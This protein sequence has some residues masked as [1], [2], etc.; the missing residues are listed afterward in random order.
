MGGISRKLRIML[1]AA[2]ALAVSCGTALAVDY[3]ITDLAAAL[4]S[5]G[6]NI[7]SGLVYGNSINNNGDVVG[8]ASFANMGNY[9]AAL[10]QN[11][12]VTDLGV[13][14][15]P[16]L[17]SQSSEAHYITDSG[18]IV[19]EAYSATTAIDNTYRQ[20]AIFSPGSAPQNIHSPM[21][22]FANN[23]FAMA[24]GN[25]YIL[26]Q[27]YNDNVTTMHATLWGNGTGDYSSVTDMN[28]TSYTSNASGLRSINSSGQIVGFSAPIPDNLSFT[29]PTLW[30]TDG[31]VKYLDL[32]KDP[33]YSGLTWEAASGYATDIN[34]NGQVSVMFSGIGLSGIWENDGSFTEIK[35]IDLLQGH[36]GSELLSLRA[37]NN[38]G[39]VAGYITV[40]DQTSSTGF[41]HAVVYENGHLIDL[42]ALFEGSG[43]YLLNALDINDKGQILV[44]AN[45]TGFD[46]S[47]STTL[48]LTPDAAPVPIPTALP[49]F[50]SGLAALGIWRRRFFCA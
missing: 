27:S 47:W 35:P 37:I 29:R 32:S 2:A 15:N 6:G 48:L 16:A 13:L 17:T 20:A 12:T 38:Q 30:D 1:L 25:G 41:S 34:N 18:L 49:L 45:H 39:A 43:W 36:D 28:P 26:G 19:G 22:Y 46:R 5:T 10:W 9:H 24:A 3:T 8:R 31:S 7:S 42:G 23:S 33:R 44:A 4:T 14:G 11:G 21:T 50:A 40:D